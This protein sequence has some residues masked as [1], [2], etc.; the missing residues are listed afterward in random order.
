MSIKRL[1]KE[2]KYM[3]PV[4]ITVSTSGEEF[5]EITHQIEEQ[6]N[7]FT[8]DYPEGILYIFIPHTSCALTINESFDPTAKDDMKKF[9][10]H[11]APESLPFIS[12]TS[13]GSDDSPSHMKS[14][15]LQTTL[16]IPVHQG[17]MMLGTWQG[18]YLCE[19][20]KDSKR[21]KLILKYREG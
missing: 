17:K 11:L 14:I 10:R 3:L 20:R 12:H 15:L 7:R 21:R 8:Q 9:L 4:E 1:L 2:G 19:F 18:I 6:L 13:E 16:T 5:Y